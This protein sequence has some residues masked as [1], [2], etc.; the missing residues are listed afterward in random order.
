M[1]PQNIL[2]INKGQVK[3]CV[4]VVSGESVNY[5]ATTFTGTSFHMAPERI[6]GQLYS[7]ACDM[8]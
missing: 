4:F 3:L 2:L 5:L 1:K 7:I 6:S 8:W